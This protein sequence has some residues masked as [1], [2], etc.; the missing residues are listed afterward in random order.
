MKL[1]TRRM[2]AAGRIVGKGAEIDRPPRPDESA[3]VERSNLYGK[4]QEAIIV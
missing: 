1:L 2:H 4:W 3:T